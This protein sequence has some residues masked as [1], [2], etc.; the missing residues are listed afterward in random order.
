MHRQNTV[1]QISRRC[2]Q[3]QAMKCP[4]TI[5]TARNHVISLIT[6]HTHEGYVATS[7][8]RMALRH[9]QRLTFFRAMAHLSLS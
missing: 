8:A 6:E 7:R 1:A 3:F 2:C 4:A 9:M 5:K